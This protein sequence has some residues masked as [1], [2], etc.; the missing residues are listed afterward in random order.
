VQA[1]AELLM[2][3]YGHP[4]PTTV[5]VTGHALAA[6]AL[7]VLACDTRIG[8]DVDARIGLNEVAIGMTLPIFAIEL[9]RD[10]LG[11]NATRASVQAEVADPQAALALGYLDK[12]VAAAD[13]EQAAISEARRLAELRSGAYSGTKSLLRQATIDH[14]LATLPADMTAI[15]GPP[16]AG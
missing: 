14:V 13:C 8:A 6:G 12:V 4:Q 15:E 3:L 1:G 7:V 2:R 16:A 10:R 5:A 9:A 11:V